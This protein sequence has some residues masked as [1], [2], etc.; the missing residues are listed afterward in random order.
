MGPELQHHPRPLIQVVV[1][2][3][4]PS[5]L[6]PDRAG[7]CCAAQVSMYAGR[8]TVVVETKGTGAKGRGHRVCRTGLRAV[9]S[10]YPP[11]GRGKLGGQFLV[12]NGANGT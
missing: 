5:A 9:D 2:L 10:W 1:R 11:R 7:W 3:P 8:D 6:T 4:E 12:G